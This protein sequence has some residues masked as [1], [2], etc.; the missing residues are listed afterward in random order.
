MTIF[1]AVACSLTLVLAGCGGGMY[2]GASGTVAAK[3]MQTPAD[4][5]ANLHEQR[6]LQ[7]PQFATQLG[8]PRGMDEWSDPSIMAQKEWA[9]LTINAFQQLK[10]NFNYDDLSDQD[11][12]SWRVLENEAMAAKR[13]TPYQL[14]SYTFNQMFGAQSSGPSFLINAHKITNTEEAWAYVSRLEGW[15]DQL[16][17]YM[18]LTM[19]AAHKGIYA[20]KFTFD[21]VIADAKNLMS[22]APFDGGKDNAVWNDFKTKLDKADINGPE[23]QQL[24]DAA[25]AAMVDNIKPAYG[26]LIDTMQMLKAKAHGSYG[27]YALP[28]GDAYYAERLKF[29]TSTDLTADEVHQIGLDE[30]ARIHNEIRGIMR[31][32]NFKGNLQ[33]FFNHT[34]ND[35]QFFFPQTP[36]GREGYLKASREAIDAMYAKLPTQFGRLP[37]ADLVVKPVEAFREKSAGRAFYNRPAS[38]GSRPGTYYVN[39]YNL[40]AVPK[41]EIEALAYHE[42]APGH[43]MQIAL[44]METQGIPEFRKHSWQTA[45]GE[46]WALYSELL[47]K[48]MGFYQDP[49]SDYGRLTMELWRAVRL[50]VDTGVHHKRWSREQTIQ[51]VLDNTPSDKLG[52][53]MA[54]NRY[55]VMPGQATA[56]K[57]GMLKIQDLRAHAQ[58]QLGNAYDQRAFH[59]VILENGPVPLDVLESIVKDWIAEQKGA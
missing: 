52:A 56:Y 19:D 2:G 35:E 22:G 33:D 46:G 9:Q 15:G 25:K 1:R 58:Q 45:Y 13:H 23:R 10:T 6:L 48:E 14:Y 17:R 44:A 53:E 27:V 3:D 36:E 47:G 28:A 21:Y 20:P 42:G 4:I 37:K 57:I 30:V 49:Y 8:D 39:L 7:S 41:Y 18:Q 12:I 50:V 32:V 26:R 51:Y 31:Q 5:F 24:E 11:K 34:R 29:H 40:K 38:D 55:M 16:D 43:H 54:I 59:D